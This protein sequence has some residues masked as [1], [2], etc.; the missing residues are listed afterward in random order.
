M[1]VICYV[2]K[3]LHV[4]YMFCKLRIEYENVNNQ[5]SQLEGADNYHLLHA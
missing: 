1:P 4:K 5:K 3:Y 2:Q